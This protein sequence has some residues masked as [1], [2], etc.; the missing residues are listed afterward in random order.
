MKHIVEEVK[1]KE[2]KE[3]DEYWGRSEQWYIVEKQHL[4]LEAKHYSERTYLVR[5]PSTPVIECYTKEQ[6]ISYGIECHSAFDNDSGWSYKPELPKPIAIPAI[7]IDVIKY[8]KKWTQ[9]LQGCTSIIKGGALYQKSD[10]Q[11]RLEAELDTYKVFISKFNRMLGLEPLLEQEWIIKNVNP[12]NKITAEE[13]LDAR[14][15]HQ[16]YLTTFKP[17]K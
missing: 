3:G 13:R 10:T 16:E 4:E 15:K 14:K 1:G 8:L 6:M 9:L 5:R 12:D 2:L 7:E 11:I 17:T